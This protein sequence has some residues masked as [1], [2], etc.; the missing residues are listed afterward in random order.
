MGRVTTGLEVVNVPF[1]K[2]YLMLRGKR[3]SRKIV[4]LSVEMFIISFKHA[5][6]LN[7]V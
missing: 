6:C 2:H 3:L 1:S 5:F 7:Y 4:M